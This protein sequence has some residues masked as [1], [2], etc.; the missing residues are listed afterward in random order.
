MLLIHFDA[1]DC[2]FPS[3]V[4]VVIVDIPYFTILIIAAFRR[5]SFIFIFI[6]LSKKILFFII[7]Q[8]H[9][10]LSSLAL[11]AIFV[12]FRRRI[13]CPEIVPPFSNF[14]S[15]NLSGNIFLNFLNSASFCLTII[16]TLFQF[17]LL[18]YFFVTFP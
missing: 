10:A 16:L 12:L 8:A 6:S 5:S 15:L 7:P 14:I 9:F 2:I 13:F 4:C 11:T 1:K 3:S 18:L 17:I